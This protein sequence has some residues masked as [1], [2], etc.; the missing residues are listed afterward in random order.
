MLGCGWYWVSIN[1]VIGLSLRFNV[2]KVICLLKALCGIRVLER[3]CHLMSR[4]LS[5]QQHVVA[6]VIPEQGTRELES[7]I[8][9]GWLQYLVIQNA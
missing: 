9:H 5:F 4:E 8:K 7:R 2:D 1:P 6:L 3:K